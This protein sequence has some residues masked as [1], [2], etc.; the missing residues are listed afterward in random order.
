M[1]VPEHQPHQ[2]RTA[3]V[4]QLAFAGHARLAATGR[5]EEE[6]IRQ[7]TLVQL[8]AQSVVALPQQIGGRLRLSVAGEDALLVAADPGV[9]CKT[10]RNGIIL[11]FVPRVPT[12]VVLTLGRFEV[13]KV[14]HELADEEVLLAEIVE[15]PE[16][17][18]EDLRLVVLGPDVG[19]QLLVGKTWD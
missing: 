2:F 13:G 10:K 16:V 18:A 1:L 4:S 9:R 19:G 5:V 17:A 3:L 12:T 8:L 11:G 14:P 7:G 6:I 15:G